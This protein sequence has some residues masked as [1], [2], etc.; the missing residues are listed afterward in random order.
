VSDAILKFD[1]F[2]GDFGMPGDVV[3]TNKM[4]IARKPGPCSHCGLEICKGDK[5]RRQASKFD[6]ELMT[7]RWCVMCC[8]AMATYDAELCNDDI[9][10]P[11]YEARSQLY[12]S[13]RIN[14]PKEVM[15]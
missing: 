14:E 1:P 4:S 7:H 10:L 3:F 9:D 5:V 12:R 8:T 11:S 15:P 6:G 2:E 13:T